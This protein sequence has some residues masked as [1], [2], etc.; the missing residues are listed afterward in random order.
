MVL[1]SL[2]YAGL[3]LLVIAMLAGCTSSL[4]LASKFV[5]EETDIHVLILPPPALILSYGPE[6]PDSIPVD[7]IAGPDDP[8]V[9]FIN[10]VDDSVFVKRFMNALEFHLEQLY[11]TWYGP[12]E[13]D[14]FFELEQPAYIFSLAQMEL[15]E[16]VEEER[17]IGRSRGT[18]YV[19]SADVTVLEN[20][21]WFEFMKLHDPDF[22][23]EVLFSV[24]ATSD[25][26]DGRFIRSEDGRVR[27][28]PE[29][30]PL[31]MRDVYELAYLSGQQNAHKIFNHLLNLYVRE[32]SGRDYPYYFHYDMTTHQIR[33][34]GQS[35][36]VEIEKAEE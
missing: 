11:I 23:M 24:H 34:S 19:G 5:V 15:I 16:Y 7:S 14:D 30:Y 28:A 1:R 3:L 32:Q 18:Q 13:M 6:H 9:R 12:G 2:K 27:F 33:E 31:N 22:E 4:Q 36:F 25:Y 35:P 26:I 20:N 29:V 21:V 17:F 10:N 8:R